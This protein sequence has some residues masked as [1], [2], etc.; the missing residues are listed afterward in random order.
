MMQEAH[1]F[2]NSIHRLEELV[3]LSRVKLHRLAVS[4]KGIAL[5]EGLIEMI[6]SVGVDNGRA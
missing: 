1:A 2:E 5:F 6:E 4:K 3:S